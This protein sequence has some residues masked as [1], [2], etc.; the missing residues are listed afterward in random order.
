MDFSSTQ[1]ASCSY[2]R[3]RAFTHASP[4]SLQP[5]HEA[6]DIPPHT[7]VCDRSPYPSSTHQFL[8]EPEIAQDDLGP[9]DQYLR[10][11]VETDR[12]YSDVAVA[13][14]EFQETFGMS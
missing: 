6:G 4:A 14:R 2:R 10:H 9:E 11:C 7:K 3:Y 1:V 8:F 5:H 13:T 12:Q